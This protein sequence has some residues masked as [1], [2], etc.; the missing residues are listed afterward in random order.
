[1]RRPQRLKAALAEQRIAALLNSSRRGATKSSRRAAAEQSS[2]DNDD[3][4]EQTEGAATRVAKRARVAADCDDMETNESQAVETADVVPLERAALVRRTW[5]QLLPLKSRTAIAAFNDHI[6]RTVFLFLE[7]TDASISARVSRNCYKYGCTAVG[8]FRANNKLR[9]AESDEDFYSIMSRFSHLHSFDLN[10]CKLVND[11]MLVYMTRM[12]LAKQM[13]Q[14]DISSTRVTQTGLNAVADVCTSLRLFRASHVAAT[15]DVYARIVR[16][17]TMLTY[18]DLSATSSVDGAVKAAG[19][20]CPDLVFL[21]L[22]WCHAT[23]VGCLAVAKGCKKLTSFRFPS[24]A[25]DVGVRQ[26]GS[27]L[28]QLRSVGFV[29]LNV[30][31]DA[32]TEFVSNVKTLSSIHVAHCELISDRGIES[33]SAICNSGLASFNLRSPGMLVS[34]RSIG[35][36]AR[37]CINLQVL[38]LRGCGRITDLGLESLGFN[39][40]NLKMLELHTLPAITPRT[41]QH[42]IEQCASLRKLTIIACD[43][44]VERAKD[45]MELAKTVRISKRRSQASPVPNAPALPAVN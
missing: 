25:T 10:G 5:A 33:M 19:E 16:N 2:D 38:K 27:N 14:L 22:S 17:N 20:S 36:I 45:L 24:H 18:L 4:Y 30:T 44:L 21:D 29:R 1:M 43:R 31:D 12:P 32:L 34:D 28:T 15:D 6:W 23:D 26:I 9:N 35:H 8:L 11:E 7:V 39:L 41:V 13:L 3:D 40:D 37:N 42:L